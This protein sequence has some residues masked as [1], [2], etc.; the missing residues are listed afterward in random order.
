[1]TDWEGLAATKYALLGQQ[2]QADTMRAQ[3]QANLMREQAA[4]LRPE[5]ADR[6]R[7]TGAKIDQMGFE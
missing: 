6:Q 5:F 4:M 2:A 7:M 1:M 3:A